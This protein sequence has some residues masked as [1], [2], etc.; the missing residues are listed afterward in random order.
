MTL[1]EKTEKKSLSF[2]KKESQD[3]ERVHV[4]LKIARSSPLHGGRRKVKN[5]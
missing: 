1:A 5:V 2:V 3:S 4:E